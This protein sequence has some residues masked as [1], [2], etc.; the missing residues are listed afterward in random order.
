M[1]TEAL[2][3]IIKKIKLS[4]EA[5]VERLQAENEKQCFE[6]ESKCEKMIENEKLK[7]KEKIEFFK[8]N[9]KAKV[10]SENLIFKNNR[11]LATKQKLI[12][13]IENEVVEKLCSDESFVKRYFNFMEQLIEAGLPQKNC[14]L[15][16]GSSD[17][18]RFLENLKFKSEGFLKIEKSNEFKYG[19][20]ICCNEFEINLNIEQ[21]VAEWFSKFQLEVSAVLMQEIQSAQE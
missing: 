2:N 20:L 5:E 7:L 14:V 8:S 3:I 9:L 18:S 12:S 16:Y 17:Y 1:N 21:L 6:I 10:N 13:K 4:A 19:A 15:F 11:I